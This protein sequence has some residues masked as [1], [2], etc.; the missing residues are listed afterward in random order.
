[1]RPRLSAKA[2][3][4]DGRRAVR[5]VSFTPAIQT[6]PYMSRIGGYSLTEEVNGTWINFYTLNGR[7]TVLDHENPAN[8]SSQSYGLPPG[9]AN[10]AT[11]RSRFP[12][13]R[14]S[15]S[16]ASTCTSSTARSTTRNTA[17]TSPRVASTSRRQTRCGSTTIRSPAT[18]SSSAAP[19][20][21]HPSRSVKVAN[22]ACAGRRG[23]PAARSS[24]R[25]Q[26][27]DSCVCQPSKSFLWRR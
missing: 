3:N 10:M 20:A 16:T 21:R 18:P 7:Y 26:P 8:M 24:R 2:A 14:R 27:L 9:D 6:V 4:P 19:R 23:W 11:A 17:T 13:R 1:M 5:R 12:T 25:W 15:A 22:G